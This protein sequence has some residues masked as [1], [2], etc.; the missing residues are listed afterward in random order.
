MKKYEAELEIKGSKAYVM[1]MKKHLLKEHPSTRGKMKVEI[2]KPERRGMKK[3]LL[4]QQKSF[5]E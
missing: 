3:C 5:W 1:Y 2:E 4:K